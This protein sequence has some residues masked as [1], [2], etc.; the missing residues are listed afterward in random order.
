MI[1]HVTIF[2]N[3]LLESKLFY[4]KAFTPFNF[5]ISFGDDGKFWA[6]DTGNKTLFEIMQYKGE[7]IL[8]PCHI[9]FR[10]RSH[11]QVQE[12]HKIA[13]EAGGKCNGT[14]GPRPQYTENYYAVFYN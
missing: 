9:A 2:V 7:N 6:F 8:T 13:L 4:E 10:A 3:D 12:F 1:D 14:L 5:K 11:E